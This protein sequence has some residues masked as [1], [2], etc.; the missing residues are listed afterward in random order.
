MNS[1][2]VSLSEMAKQI[3]NGHKVVLFKDCSVPMELGRTLIKQGTKGLHLV[4]V[5]TGS[6]L[7]DM[8]IGAGCVATVETSGVSL[9][10]FGLAPQFGSAVKSGRIKI[11][12]ATCPAIYAGLQAAEKGLPFI[13]LRG[14][15]GSDVLKNRED[16]RV[17][18]NPFMENDPIVVLPA[19]APDVA[20][21]HA[22]MADVYGNVY[23]AR[24]AELKIISHAAT[25]TL[26]TVE[27]IVDFNILEQP[28][29]APAALSAMYVDGI[30]LVPNGA[31]PLN[32]PGYYDYDRSSIKA[33][34]VAA[35]NDSSFKTWLE[36]QNSSSKANSH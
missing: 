24:Q 20:I 14:L 34:A 35:E 16:F 18:D 33:Y 5:P 2:I 25:K 15:I 28:E 31:W 30:A 13:P 11:L 29:L 26:V 32:L 4:T 1:S 6:M 7:P 22:G 17:I 23:I 8:L 19:I 21:F 27:E 36:T 10:E 12:D 3:K 9:G